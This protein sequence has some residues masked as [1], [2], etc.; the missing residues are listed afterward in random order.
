VVPGGRQCGVTDVILEVEVSVVYPNGATQS[1]RNR[2]QFLTE[3]R[4]H[5]ES[6]LDHV[7]YLFVFRRWTLE[8]GDPANVHVGIGTLE[9]KEKLV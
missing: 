7:L 1:E 3:A 8:N 6:T 5:L 4:H 9:M 2:H